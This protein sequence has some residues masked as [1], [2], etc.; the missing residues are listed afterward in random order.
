MAR[1]S[2]AAVDAK[3][4]RRLERELV[5]W[6]ATVGA[7]GRPSVVP[8]WFLWDGASFLIYSVPGVKVRNVEGNP[9]V[10]LHLNSTSDGG[11]VVRIDGT[12]R[13]ARRQPPAYK[14][15]AYVRKYRAL[16]KS[17]GWTPESFS[18]EYHVPVKVKATKVR[19]Q[20]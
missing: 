12:A 17:Y 6:L 2:P 3:T 20:S 9:N 1:T 16:I 19:T 5:A 11:D 8:V 4:R 10:E 15:P 14:V 7:D 18:A 13:V